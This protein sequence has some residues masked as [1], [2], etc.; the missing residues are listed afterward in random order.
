[1]ADADHS[2]AFWRSVA[3]TFKDDHAVVFE[4]FNEPHDIS[5][6]CWEHGCLTGDGWRTAGMQ[7]L[8]NAVRGT[9]ATNVVLVGGLGWSSDLSAWLR[10]RPNDPTGQLAATFHTYNFSGCSTQACWD[11]T[12]AKVAKQ[13]PGGDD[14]DRRER[15]RRRLRRAADGLARPARDL[16]P[17]LDLGHLGLHQRAGPDHVVRRHADRL[18]ADRA[19][20]L[21][22]PLSRT[23]H[24]EP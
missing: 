9:G 10:H 4:L 5:W 12:V 7:Q 22:Q 14:R 23:C 15:L 1:M 16:L 3:K 2:P 11:A 8:L 20:P 13:V 18:R 21:P 24:P 17:R 19:R 6:R